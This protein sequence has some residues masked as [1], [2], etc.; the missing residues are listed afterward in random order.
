MVSDK[1]KKNVWTEQLQHGG[2]QKNYS[3]TSALSLTKRERIY[4]TVELRSQ[5]INEFIYFLFVKHSLSFSAPQNDLFFYSL[6]LVIGVLGS[7]KRMCL[8]W[9]G[10]VCVCASWPACVRVLLVVE[11]P[12]RSAKQKQLSRLKGKWSDRCD[13]WLF[14][15]REPVSSQADECG[16]DCWLHTLKGLPSS[17][18]LWSLKTDCEWPHCSPQCN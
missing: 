8:N 7:R 16:P 6:L 14:M 10:T 2:R 15:G 17:L 12:H 18:E 4:S 13:V 11:S 5:K 9:E 3:K 1:L